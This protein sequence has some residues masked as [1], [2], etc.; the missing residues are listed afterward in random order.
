MVEHQVDRFGLVAPKL[1]DSNYQA[2][3]TRC[4]SHQVLIPKKYPTLFCVVRWT[5]AKQLHT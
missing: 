3:N 2:V 4:M 5:N 1:M